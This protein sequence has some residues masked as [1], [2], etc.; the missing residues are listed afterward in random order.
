MSLNM[1]SR[2]NRASRDGNTADSVT[3]HLGEGSYRMRH[4]HHASR[5]SLDDMLDRHS[6]TQ[7]LE[8]SASSCRSANGRFRRS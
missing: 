1:K 6:R 3:G 5:F 4:R 2:E 8:R 7:E